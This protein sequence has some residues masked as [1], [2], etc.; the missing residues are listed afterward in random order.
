M[1]GISI[2]KKKR[3]KEKSVYGNSGESVFKGKRRE[4]GE[5]KGGKKRGRR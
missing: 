1:R 2:E 4:I 5:I 3:R